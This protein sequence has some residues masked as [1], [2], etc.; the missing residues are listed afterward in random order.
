MAISIDWAKFKHNHLTGKELRA[1]IPSYPSDWETC[2]MQ[3]SYAFNQSTDPITPGI[4]SRYKDKGQNYILAVQEMRAY[5]DDR[6]KNGEGYMA[7]APDNR[8]FDTNNKDKKISDA[9]KKR[10]HAAQAEY[11]KYEVVYKSQIIDRRG[12]IAFGDR[13]IDIW[14]RTNIHRPQAYYL[15][16]LWEADSTRKIGIFFWEFE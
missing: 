1:K 7:G 4:H 5:L 3:V 10:R 12:L 9:E 2:C 16:E 15:N 8:T 14:D 13:H 11:A 6:Y